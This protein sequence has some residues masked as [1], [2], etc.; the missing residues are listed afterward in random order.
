MNISNAINQEIDKRH[1]P[2]AP[3]REHSNSS[4]SSHDPKDNL[5]QVIP[6]PGHM[7][8]FPVCSTI[9]YSRKQEN[10]LRARICWPDTKDKKEN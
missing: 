3:N 9:H 6:G 10:I 7:L 1:L 8:R 2:K 5:C 4:S